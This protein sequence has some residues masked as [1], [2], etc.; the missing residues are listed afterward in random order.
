MSNMTEII[1][2]LLTSKQIH[3]H[4]SAEN[5]ML[6]EMDRF[7][8]RE[9]RSLNIEG[10]KGFQRGKIVNINSNEELFN[11]EYLMSP[12]PIEPLKFDILQLD[13][14]QLIQKTLEQQIYNLSKI[15]SELLNSNKK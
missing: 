4:S 11:N 5:N 3:F 15:P 8:G 2:E 13:S 12:I 14:Q 9:S 1:K 10:M 6:K 7:R